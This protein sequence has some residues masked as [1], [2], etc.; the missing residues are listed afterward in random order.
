[1]YPSVAPRLLYTPRGS[2]LWAPAS[3]PR[4]P[5]SPPP[6]T[7]ASAPC[8]PNLRKSRRV[9]LRVGIFSVMLVSFLSCRIGPLRVLGAA[10]AAPGEVSL[11]ALVRPHV[12]LG[13]DRSHVAVE[14]VVRGSD[15]AEGRRADVY[16]RRTCQYVVVAGE[17]PTRGRVDDHRDERRVSAERD[18]GEAGVVL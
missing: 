9:S 7:R 6:A 11:V 15:P 1:M 17:E 5:P 2:W 10:E 8:P 16:G 4:P 3:R 14:V 13:A 18:G 12:G